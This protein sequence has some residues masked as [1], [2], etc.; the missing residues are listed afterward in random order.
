MTTGTYVLTQSKEAAP[1]LV[2][3]VIF[4]TLMEQSGTTANDTGSGIGLSGGP[5]NAPYTAT[6]TQISGDADLGDCLEFDRLS[7]DKANA[8]DVESTTG[9]ARITFIIAIKSNNA[10]NAGQAV[11]A[12]NVGGANNGDFAVTIG[13]G[14]TDANFIVQTD[15]AETRV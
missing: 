3:P 13:S 15:A 11:M 4:W 5:Y 12:N 10:S 1:A 9:I 2:D 7:D 8:G 6:P 14:A